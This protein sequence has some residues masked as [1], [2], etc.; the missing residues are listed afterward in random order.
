MNQ[1]YINDTKQKNLDTKDYILYGSTY[2]KFCKT[3]K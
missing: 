2:T 1:F 3:Q